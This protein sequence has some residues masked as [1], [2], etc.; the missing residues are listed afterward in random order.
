[1]T[2]RHSAIRPVRLST[3]LIWALTARAALR[4]AWPAI[5]R[6]LSRYGD[7]CEYAWRSV[8]AVFT[9]CV[10]GVVL[11]LVAYGLHRDRH[12]GWAMVTLCAAFLGVVGV[13][14]WYAAGAVKVVERRARER[15]ARR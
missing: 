12:E 5:R 8:C 2:G 14:A 9:G 3:P 4:R 13:L 6:V 7:W 11:V 1:V 15:R 10:L